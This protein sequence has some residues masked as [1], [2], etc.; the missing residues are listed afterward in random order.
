MSDPIESPNTA[1]VAARDPFF[2]LRDCRDLM[3]RRLTDIARLAGVSSPQLLAAYAREIGE[4]HDEL[5]SSSRADGFEQT[6]GLTASRISLVGN[7]DLEL[8]IR[9]GDI[10]RKSVV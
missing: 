3:Q 5:A 4:A 6:A 2:V 7:D 10:D 9:I 1:P 8:E